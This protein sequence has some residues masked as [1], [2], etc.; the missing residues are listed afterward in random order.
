MSEVWKDIKGFEGLYA[1]SNC[2]RIKSLKR[3][4]ANN[5]YGGQRVL[6]EQIK[7]PLDNGN[8]YKYVFLSEKRKRQRFYIHRLVAEH[9]LENRQ[10]KK[11][12]NHLDYNKANNAAINLQW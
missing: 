7:N 5:K 3:V 6:K 8:G 1:V 11:Y 9:F 4:V 12:V 2:G 10:N